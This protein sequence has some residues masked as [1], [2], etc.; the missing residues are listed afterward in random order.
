[1]KTNQAG[2]GNNRKA[3][4]SQG[5]TL[6]AKFRNGEFATPVKP[7]LDRHEKIVM[8]MTGLIEDRLNPTMRKAIALLRIFAREHAEVVRD[9]TSARNEIQKADGLE[10]LGDQVA[11]ELAELIRWLETARK[12]TIEETAR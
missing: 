12:S 10:Y 5:Q 4:V 6:S 3:P 2:K 7:A 1:M 11:D 9:W 8:A